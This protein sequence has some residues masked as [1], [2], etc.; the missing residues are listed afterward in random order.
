MKNDDDTIRIDGYDFKITRPPTNKWDLPGA[1]A[2]VHTA[3]EF[4][5]QVAGWSRP[6]PRGEVPLWLL[7][8]LYPVFWVVLPV[9]A[10]RLVAWLWG[11]ARG[12][13]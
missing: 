3:A 6:R 2:Y 5:I 9:T 4:G 12:L 11:V 1:P 10:M 7:V 13:L 8:L